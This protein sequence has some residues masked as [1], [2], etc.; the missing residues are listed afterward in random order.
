MKRPFP[1]IFFLR[2]KQKSPKT[3]HAKPTLCK[4][5]NHKI[6]GTVS[7]VAHAR[8]SASEHSRRNFTPLQVWIRR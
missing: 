8:L 3:N 7:R 5:C 2:G 6:K 1:G 4:E